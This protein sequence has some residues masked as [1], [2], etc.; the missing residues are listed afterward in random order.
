VDLEYEAS[1]PNTHDDRYWVSIVV[2]LTNGSDEPIP[3]GFDHFSVTSPEVWSTRDRRPPRSSQTLARWTRAFHRGS[4]PR[5]ACCFHCAT[6]TFPRGCHTRLAR[7]ASRPM[8]NP[9]C[10]RNSRIFAQLLGRVRTPS[11]ATV[12][13]WSNARTGK[14]GS[15]PKAVSRSRRRQHAEAAR[16]RGAGSRT[17]VPARQEV[18]LGCDGLQMLRADPSACPGARRAAPWAAHM[19]GPA[20]RAEACGRP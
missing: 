5:V 12:T 20:A 4:A 9:A 6:M 16:S 13:A 19:S 1:T 17:D 14:R 3:L 18:K 2:Q 8:S 11:F 10:T 7:R 15:I